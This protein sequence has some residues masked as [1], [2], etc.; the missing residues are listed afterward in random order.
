MRQ[1]PLKWKST[2]DKW[3]CWV[4]CRWG[5]RLP[6]TH[7]SSHL[8]LLWSL[9]KYGDRQSLYHPHSFLIRHT[10]AIKAPS[11]PQHKYREGDDLRGYG[12][13]R[14]CVAFL[15]SERHWRLVID[16]S[17]QWVSGHQFGLSEERLSGVK[18]Q[19]ERMR[20]W[21]G[22]ML[23]EGHMWMLYRH[24]GKNQQHLHIL[25]LMPRYREVTC[26]IQ[27]VL[28]SNAIM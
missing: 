10:A 28:S 24:T 17:G 19:L 26:L 14:T 8:M 3:K 5:W 20:S 6:L 21:R 11:F 2:A 23:V 15:W 27:A 16:C 12:H 9:R 22:H 18:G 7:Q 25:D 1:I 13:C 4:C